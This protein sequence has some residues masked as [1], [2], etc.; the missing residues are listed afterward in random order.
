MYEKDASQLLIR[1]ICEKYCKNVS[2]ILEII[3]D[4]LACFLSNLRSSKNVFAVN[5]V[6]KGHE[7]T[8][9]M[10]EHAG[11]RF[12]FSLLLSSACQ[13]YAVTEGQ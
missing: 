11:L 12:N 8:Q 9:V 2:I 4:D 5:I 7:K 3:P 13:M 6:C 1:I 10:L